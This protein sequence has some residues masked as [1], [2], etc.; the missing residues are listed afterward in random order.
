VEPSSSAQTRTGH[1]WPRLT[2][3]LAR[4]DKAWRACDGRVF[5][6]RA[7]PVPAYGARAN[8][9]RKGEI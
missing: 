4:Q 2:V 7:H 3:I 6:V 8:P 9:Y 1:E 5:A